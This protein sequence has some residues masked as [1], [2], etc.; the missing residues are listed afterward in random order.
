MGPKPVLPATSELFR[1]RLDEQINMRHP[2]VRLSGFIDW[3]L[4]TAVV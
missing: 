1:Q 3:S 2:L 4:E